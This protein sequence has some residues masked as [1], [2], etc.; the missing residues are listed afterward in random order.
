MKIIYKIEVGDFFM[1][2][3]DYVMEDEE[4]AYT[5]GNVYGCHIKGCITDNGGDKKHDMEN[6]HDFFEYF[7]L[8]NMS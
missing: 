8:I 2:L 6:E 5:S 3:K 7:E 4:I 1:C